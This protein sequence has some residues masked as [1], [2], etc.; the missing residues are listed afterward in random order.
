VVG[1]LRGFHLL[2]SYASVVTGEL[3]HLIV[4]SAIDVTSLII[5][6]HSKEPT[7]QLGD[8]DLMMIIFIFNPVDSNCVETVTL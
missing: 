1:I 4:D 8:L 3:R 7:Q 5:H 2:E 6:S